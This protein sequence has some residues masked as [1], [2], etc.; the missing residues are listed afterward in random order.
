LPHPVHQNRRDQMSRAPEIEANSTRSEETSS[1]P[2]E[3]RQGSY[4]SFK[5]QCASQVLLATATIKVTVSWGTQQPC[6]V[7][8]VRG[9]QS[10]YITEAFAQRL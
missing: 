8:V 4:C 1:S 9:S 6:R 7:L 5:E 2:T 3:P 10:S